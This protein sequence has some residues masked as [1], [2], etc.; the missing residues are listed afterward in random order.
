M[1]KKKLREKY[2]HMR[3]SIPQKEISRMSYE[4]FFQLKK[5]F[6]IWKKTYYHIFLPI[7][8]YKEI[9]TFIMINFL[10]KIGKCV[11]I[12]CS[13][14]RELSMDNCLFH[15]N[16][17]L[18]KKK[19]GILEPIPIHKYTVSISLIDVIF[20]P[21]LIFDLKGY[22]VGYGKGFYDRFISSCEKKAIKIGLS[23]FPPIGEIKNIHKNDLSID[24]GI[25]PNHIFFFEKF[26]GK[27]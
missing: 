7:Y 1:N 19:Y 11:T 20:I 14:F 3:K 12:P 4:I 23:F 26:K 5:I 27:L 21:L 6:F 18:K 10:L 13:N 22:R 16:I 15:N 2:F 17:I 8:E 24:I 25:T 9:D